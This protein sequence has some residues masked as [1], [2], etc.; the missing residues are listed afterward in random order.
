MRIDLYNSSASQIASDLNPQ[1]VSA[2]GS[3]R[4]TNS[5]GVSGDDRT[6]LSSGSTAVASLV[7]TALGSPEVRQDKIDS[8]RQAIGNGQ[9]QVDPA[10]I[11][12]SMAGE[13]A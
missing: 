8:L 12:A 2:Q 6:S 10:S 4:A 13:A 7:S 11:A 3:G 9:Y 1:Q 5:E